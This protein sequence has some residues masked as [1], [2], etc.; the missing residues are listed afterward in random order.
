[1][2]HAAQV[3][4]V[5]RKGWDSGQM[6]QTLSIGGLFLEAQNTGLDEH[7]NSRSKYKILTKVHNRTGDTFGPTKLVT[8]DSA[9]IVSI[10]CM[11]LCTVLVCFMRTDSHAL[12]PWVTGL[13]CPNYSARESLLFA[14]IHVFSLHFRFLLVILGLCTCRVVFIVMEIHWFVMS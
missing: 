8:I 14:F 7:Q 11:I 6:V 2:V 4:E 10:C 13:S 5:G 1:M 9:D 12:C 3:C